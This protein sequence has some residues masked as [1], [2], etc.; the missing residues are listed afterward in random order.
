MRSCWQP[1]NP[2]YCCHRWKKG[3]PRTRCHQMA[4]WHLLCICSQLRRLHAYPNET[5][6]PTGLGGISFCCPF[7]EP[8]LP[9][10]PQNRDS[11]SSSPTQ[12]R[13]Q[14]DRDSHVLYL[15]VSKSGSSAKS[16]IIKDF[17]SPPASFYVVL[18]R[19]S[20]AM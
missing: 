2:P 16:T 20:L 10:T 3:K 18:S 13:P 6:S 11:V 19:H 8:R 14:R 17:P 12:P 7:K 5:P 9:A 4:Q 1:A 15:I